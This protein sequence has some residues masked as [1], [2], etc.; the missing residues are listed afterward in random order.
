MA[1]ADAAGDRVEDDIEGLGQQHDRAG[2]R[3]G[4]AEGVGQIGE[5][6]QAGHRAERTGGDGPEGIADPHGTRQRLSGHGGSMPAERQPAQGVV[7][8]PLARSHRVTPWI[9]TRARHRPQ[10]QARSRVL[11][12]QG[13]NNH[14]PPRDSSLPGSGQP[15][16]LRLGAAHRHRTTGNRD[17][18]SQ[19]LVSKCLTRPRTHNPG[20][21]ANRSTGNRRTRSPGNLAQPP[22]AQPGPP[23]YGQAAVRAGAERAGRRW[24][25]LAYGQR[26]PVVPRVVAAP[27][28][29]PFH[30]LGRN[31]KFR[32]WRPLAGTALLVA[33]AL[34]LTL[35]IL[36]GW[37][38]VHR[39]VAGNF[40]APKA[41]RSSPT[42]PRTCP[43]SW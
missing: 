21:P 12:R 18:R 34:M 10:S 14:P 30:R 13:A 7:H 24:G 23:Q 42:R 15:S 4:D 22:Y 32:W 11:R 26:A 6:Q 33:L 31:A 20:S 43:L 5:Q 25:Q 9:R 17:S 37:E 28:G 41:T 3:G 29:E 40:T 27:P 2:C 35:V 16:S 39:V 38:V 1:V 19:P 36:I 8:R